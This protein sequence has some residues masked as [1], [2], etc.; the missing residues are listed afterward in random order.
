MAS[1][2]EIT[3]ES[4]IADVLREHPG[5]IDVFD[6]HNMPCRTCMGVSTDT[7]EEGANMH[8]VN[9]DALIKELRDCSA[10]EG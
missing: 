3:K 6:R 1:N 2:I 4:V 9:L 7:L 10:N 8:D 5:C